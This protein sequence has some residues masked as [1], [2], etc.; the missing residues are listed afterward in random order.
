VGRGGQKVADVASVVAVGLVVW[1]LSTF[2]ASPLPEPPPLSGAWPRASPPAAMAV[3]QMP[4]GATHR[5]AAVDYRGGGVFDKRDNVMTVVLVKHPRGDILIDTGFG[6]DID[7][8]VRMLPAFA[9][10]FT[11]YTRGTPAAEQL[12]A[13][14]YDRRAL[15]GI[16][17][18]LERS[19]RANA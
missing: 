18:Q 7:R 14:G 10:A 17:R 15:R 4:T 16:L 6:R 2:T 13:A 12:D 8:H 3:Y 1:L 11:S 19:P 9:R 5:R